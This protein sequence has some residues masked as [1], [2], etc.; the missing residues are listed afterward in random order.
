[1]LTSQLSFISEA[2]IMDLVL[3]SLGKYLQMEMCMIFQSITIEK[4]EILNIHKYLMSKNDVK[5]C[6]ALLNKCLLGY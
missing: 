4:S 3:L 5:K 1:M 6:S 2:Y